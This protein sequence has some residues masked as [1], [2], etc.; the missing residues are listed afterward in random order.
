MAAS[1]DRNS[2]TV[3][4]THATIGKAAGR[5]V[6]SSSGIPGLAN[7]TEWWA[8]TGLSKILVRPGCP[9]LA[10]YYIRVIKTGT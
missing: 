10:K 9:G 1:R 6:M 5:Q 3:S 4:I 7:C 2:P 8:G